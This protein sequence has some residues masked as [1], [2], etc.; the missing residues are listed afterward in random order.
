MRVRILGCDGGPGPGRMPMSILINEHILIDAGSAASVLSMEERSR[1][2]HIFISHCH[3]DHTRD[4]GFLPAGRDMNEC[5]ALTLCGTKSVLN[6][7]RRTVFTDRVW[8]DFSRSNSGEA[9]SLR[10]KRLRFHEAI[11]VGSV[12]VEAIPV[13]HTCETAGFVIEDEEGAVVLSSD[14]GPTKTLWNRANSVGR[15]RAVFVDVSLPDRLN[16]QALETGH[17]TPSLMKEELSK[18]QCEDARIFA[19][20]LKPEYFEEVR[21]ELMLTDPKIEIPGSG[22]TYNL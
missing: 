1:I 10:Y 13:N 17:M 8:F 14:T 5:D 7:L 15:I 16:D 4:L 22:D 18:V 20:H 12:R 19:Y 6:I 11:Q 2:T 21:R 9:P 3:L